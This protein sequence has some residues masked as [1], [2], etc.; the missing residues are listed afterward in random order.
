VKTTFVIVG[1]LMLMH[2]I[3]FAQ[4]QANSPKKAKS[5]VAMTISTDHETVVSGSKVIVTVHLTNVSDHRIGI[6]NHFRVE[7]RNSQGQ[8]A[9]YTEDHGKR[10]R[11]EP[12]YN[13]PILGGGFRNIAYW[14][15][16]GQTVAEEIEVTK[17]Y[18][19]TIPGKYTIRVFGL[20]RDGGAV[21]VQ[22]TNAITLTVGE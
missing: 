22:S 18:D 5:S 6:D 1:V 9:P 20:D 10:L 21:E 15:E 13:Q 12:P 11:R 7:I 3:V 19:L 16:K 8:L 4:Q 14:V 2:S 17:Q